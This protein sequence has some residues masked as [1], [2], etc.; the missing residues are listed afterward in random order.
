MLSRTIFEEKFVAGHRP[1]S[2]V[3]ASARRLQIGEVV[4][5]AF[6]SGGAMIDTGGGGRTKSAYTPFCFEDDLSEIFP[7]RCGVEGRSDSLAGLERVISA[8]KTAS[9]P[10]IRRY[11][12]VSTGKTALDKPSEKPAIFCRQRLN[13][14]FDRARIE[15]F[16]RPSQEV[17]RLLEW[18]LTIQNRFINRFLVFL[19]ILL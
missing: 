16:H 18:I 2:R 11:D 14:L 3:T 17:N 7:E 8:I 9:K 4:V 6:S 5:A 10:L 1:F 19:G 13:D 15:V 12:P